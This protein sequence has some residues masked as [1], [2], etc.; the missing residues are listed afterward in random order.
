MYSTI[1]LGTGTGHPNALSCGSTVPN[2]YS[3]SA[4]LHHPHQRMAFNP[5]SRSQGSGPLVN[6]GSGPIQL[7]QFLL[8]LLTDKECQNCI[9]WT[10]DG[11]EFKMADPDEVGGSGCHKSNYSF[12][13]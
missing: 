1:R 2:M 7:W 4:I 9:C 11:W 10:G 12:L 6:P 3:S 8:E 5:E 13:R